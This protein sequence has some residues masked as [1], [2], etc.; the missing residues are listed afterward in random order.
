LKKLKKDVGDFSGAIITGGVSTA[1][2]AGVVG[3]APAAAPAMGGFAA[4]GGMMPLVGTTMMGGNVIRM[5][6]KLNKGG[7]KSYM[8][9]KKRTRRRRR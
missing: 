9:K 3:M 2:G 4:M 5:T 7:S 6:K 1:V 8:P